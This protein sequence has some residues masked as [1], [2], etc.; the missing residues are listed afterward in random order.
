MTQNQQAIRIGRRQSGVV[1][2][3]KAAFRSMSTASSSSKRTTVGGH[4]PFDVELHQV[5]PFATLV[6]RPF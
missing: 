1:Q 3:V 6:G 4:V 5:P 2:S